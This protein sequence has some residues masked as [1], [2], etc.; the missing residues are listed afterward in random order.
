STRCTTKPG[1]RARA[2]AGAPSAAWRANAAR[3]TAQPASANSNPY[4]LLDGRRQNS[5]NSSLSD[6]YFSELRAFWRHVMVG[7]LVMCGGPFGGLCQMENS[8]K[9]R[10]LPLESTHQGDIRNGQSAGRPRDGAHEK[11]GHRGPQRRRR[12][13]G[14]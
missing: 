13:L 12:F 3:S 7:L 2:G 6:L 5:V 14:G 9:L 1:C 11:V 8:A 10:A 4:F